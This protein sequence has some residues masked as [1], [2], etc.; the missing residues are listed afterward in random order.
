[1]PFG[2]GG[3]NQAQH[4]A[5][6]SNVVD[7]GSV[8]KALE[9]VGILTGRPVDDSPERLASFSQGYHSALQELDQMAWCTEGLR[10]SAVHRCVGL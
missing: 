8:L 4:Q 1:M 3:G 5:P 7:F 6:A 10:S 2:R 9:S